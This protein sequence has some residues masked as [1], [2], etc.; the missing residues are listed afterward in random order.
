MMQV[1][2]SPYFL[3]HLFLFLLIKMLVLLQVHLPQIITF[4]LTDLLCMPIVLCLSLFFTQG[5]RKLM[6]VDQKKDEL[7]IP[8]RYVFGLTF[9]WSVFFERYLPSVSTHYTSDKIDVLMYVF[10][11]IS[12]VI[13]M[14]RF[15]VKSLSSLSIKDVVRWI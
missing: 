14:K 11:A 3:V 10:G 15:D 2:R 12:F 6:R 5:I 7:Q 8:L 9:F 1:L 4:Y 13:W